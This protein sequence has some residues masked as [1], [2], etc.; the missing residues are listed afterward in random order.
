MHVQV[1]TDSHIRGS[2][3]LTRRIEA[4]VDAVL[5]RFA[6][7][8]TRVE[9]QL[10]DVNSRKSGSDDKRCLIEVRPAGFEPIVASHQAGTLEEAIEAALEKA[11]KALTR[12][13]G[14]RSNKKGQVAYG[15]AQ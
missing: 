10:N 4:D 6:D 5:G 13:V 15:D 14:K 12:A 1:N 11:E 8:I 3:E 9:I 7:R 2:E